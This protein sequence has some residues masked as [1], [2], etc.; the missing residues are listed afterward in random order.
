MADVAVTIMLMPE[1]AD[2]D[3]DAMES[4]VRSRVKVHSIQ[5]EPIAFGLQALK[6]IA[7]VPDAEGGTDALEEALAKVRG[8][9]NVQVV[10]L[11]RLL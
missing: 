2:V 1:S 9:G 7:V 10:G 4:E 6:I 11:T 5:R 3:M 8:V